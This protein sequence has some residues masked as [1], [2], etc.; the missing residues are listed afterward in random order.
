[1]QRTRKL[2]SCQNL[3]LSFPNRT[4]KNFENW[5]L[6]KVLMAKMNLNWDFALAREIIHGHENRYFLKTFYSI[7]KKFIFFCG[8]KILGPNYIIYYFSKFVY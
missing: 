5:S 6:D 8:K 7:M 1:M 3:D 2:F 4:C